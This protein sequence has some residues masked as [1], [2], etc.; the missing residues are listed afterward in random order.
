MRVVVVVVVVVVG[1]GNGG[2]VRS[3]YCA[4]VRLGVKGCV[5]IVRSIGSACS[6]VLCPVLRNESD[7]FACHA[8]ARTK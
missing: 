8:I 5:N 1:G 2:C 3:R 6:A 7:E 4:R